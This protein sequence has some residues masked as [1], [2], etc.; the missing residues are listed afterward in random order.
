MPGPVGLLGYRVTSLLR[1]G[2]SNSHCSYRWL[3]A[4]LREWECVNRQPERAP[5]ARAS[6]TSCHGWTRL[7]IH[8][9]PGPRPRPGAARDFCGGIRRLTGQW[10][11]SLRGGRRCCH[12]SCLR[13]HR[14]VA[15]GRRHCGIDFPCLPNTTFSLHFST[16]LAVLL[17]A[18]ASTVLAHS[19]PAGIS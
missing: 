4:C 19:L 3:L 7:G 8:W 17:L 11:R 15:C 2:S 14:Q 1:L 18:R 5:L 12:P 16:L 6:S 10:S 9:R 13:P